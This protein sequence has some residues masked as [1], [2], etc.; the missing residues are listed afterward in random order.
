MVRF[1]RLTYSYCTFLSNFIIPYIYAYYLDC[2]IYFIN[3]LH[4]FNLVKVWFFFSASLRA[5]APSF[6]ILLYSIF[7]CIISIGTH[8]SYINYLNP[9]GLYYGSFSA[10]HLELLHLHFQSHYPLYICALFRL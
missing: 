10:P 3:H 8:I 2:R 9:T 1:K 4:K 6:P 5:I 7:I